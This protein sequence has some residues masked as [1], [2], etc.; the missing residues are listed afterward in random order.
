MSKTYTVQPTDRAPEGG[1][2]LSC[3]PGNFLVIDGPTELSEARLFNAMHKFG[4]DSARSTKGQ[5][6]L[7]EEKPAP[8]P[9]PAPTIEPDPEPEPE[10]V[11]EPEP[12]PEQEPEPTEPE[13]TPELG[14]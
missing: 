4:P 10:P 1:V 11:E 8:T 6:E 5:L 7:V 12:E 14:E 9:A 3:G 13:T 2:L